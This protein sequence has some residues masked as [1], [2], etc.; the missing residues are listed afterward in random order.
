M[1]IGDER[2]C[3]A[4]A[5]CELRLI[6][7]LLSEAVAKLSLKTFWLTLLLLLSARW[8]AQTFRGIREVKLVRPHSTLSMTH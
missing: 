5:G 7:T 1:Q 2:K 4:G 6:W 8:S 3:T